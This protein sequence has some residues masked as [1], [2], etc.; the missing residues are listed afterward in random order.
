[1]II[2]QK[3]KQSKPVNGIVD[4]IVMAIIVSWFG[5]SGQGGMVMA[6]TASAAVSLSLY[7]YDFE[8]VFADDEDDEQTIIDT[9]TWQTRG[10]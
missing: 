4:V 3:F 10:A 5:S 2:I 8:S 1:M 9:P 6:M 7:G